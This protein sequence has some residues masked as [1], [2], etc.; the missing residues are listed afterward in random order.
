MRVG[1][2]PLNG[3]LASYPDDALD[4]AADLANLTDDEVRDIPHLGAL[5]D[6]PPESIVGNSGLTTTS[7]AMLSK[8]Q[9]AGLVVSGLTSTQVGAL[10][11]TG[12]AGLSA[13]QLGALLTGAGTPAEHDTLVFNGTKWVSKVATTVV[14]SAVTM[15]PN[16]TVV[17]ADN[18]GFTTAPAATAEAARLVVADADVN[19]GVTFIERYLSS[20]MGRTTI[21][22]GV[23][24]FHTYA[25]PSS[26]AGDNYI[27]TRINKRVLQSGMT[28]TFTGAG[29][30]R[31]FTVT[32][33]TPF[34]AGD[35]SADVTVASLIETPTQT[36]WITGYTS[37]SVVTV[38]MTDP[39]FVNVAG[40]TLT[41]IHYRLFIN[42]SPDMTTAGVV[43][44][45]INVNIQ[46][47]FTIGA[48][49][50]LC[51]AYFAKT[52]SS[53]ARNITFYIA[54]S[55][56][57][58]HI[59]TPLTTRHADLAGL[60]ENDH[61]QYDLIADGL[62]TT[63]LSYITT[64]Q[65]A[66]IS[67]TQVGALT[68]T[69]VATLQGLGLG[70]T[71]T[72][73]TTMMSSITTTHMAALSITA[74]GGLSH[75]QVKGLTQGKAIELSKGANVAS[76]ST[77]DLGAITD[78]NVIHITG[79]TAITSFGTAPTA[80]IVRQVIFD[81]ALTLTHN[82]S[83]LVLPGA[84][85]LTTRADDMIVL[86]ADTTTKWR[87]FGYVGLTG[88]NRAYSTTNNS[89]HISG[90]DKTTAAGDVIIGHLT[91]GTTGGDNVILGVRAGMFS[92]TGTQGNVLVGYCAGAHSGDGNGIRG[93]RNT[94][95]GYNAGRFTSTGHR[96][97]MI[98]SGDG[99]AGIFTSSG[100]V[101]DEM[102]IQ[103]TLYATGLNTG[104]GRK[105]GIGVQA[106]AA[107]LDIDTG[108]DVLG[109]RVDRTTS[110]STDHIV[111]FVSNVGGTNT[112]V[113]YIDS[114]GAVFHTSDMRVK[115]NITD[116]T[117]KLA[118][119]MRVRVVNY[120][121]INDDASKKSLGV[122]AQEIQDIWP[123]M[124]VLGPVPTE[125]MRDPDYVFTEDEL[126]TKQVP[127]DPEDP[128][129]ERRDETDTERASRLTGC[130]PLI[131][132]PCGEPLLS[133]ATDTI[134]FILIK[135]LQEAVVEI[136]ALAARV[137]ALEAI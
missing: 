128:K 131:H 108:A 99:D 22:A 55:T 110:T 43:N 101:S 60:T 61:P 36:A 125:V 85:N 7:L 132:V 15:Y 57:Y 100:S 66:A 45:L 116:A 104:V 78:G 48:T 105:I 90:G 84:A 135:A 51:A 1:F 63:A 50:S 3:G 38:T 41:A 115:V 97:V 112:T 89:Y 119:L 95:V 133:V 59:D 93:S 31:T 87:V 137:T 8:T 102:N 70:G 21:P 4:A 11:T 62:T 37:S 94:V 117:P 103:N 29:A 27:L 49:D 126:E 47:E 40:A 9:V 76:A 79:T 91:G 109:L 42:T 127:I 19:G 77:V 2:D 32:G 53:T 123:K 33:G 65:I 17:T 13:T 130:R 73:T 10:T 107:Q 68:T 5:V 16:E 28:G 26:V 83:T 124:V 54:G 24:G 81:G 64:T 12:L 20:A 96:N 113:G 69:Q 58:S 118:D 111:D 82:A 35:A 56:N 98:G 72:M 18:F 23:W 14:G 39:A 6:I 92:S 136:R 129:S 134:P 122:L 34:I 67:T 114:D 25:M 74:L 46:P 120:N 44:E 30:T 71:D 106:P 88:D 121:K 86:I 80:G 52:T 75:T